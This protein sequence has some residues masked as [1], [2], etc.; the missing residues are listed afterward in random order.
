MHTLKYK[1]RYMGGVSKVEASNRAGTEAEYPNQP[2]AP[3]GVAL[4]VLQ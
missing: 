3:A 4:H 1:E 2:S